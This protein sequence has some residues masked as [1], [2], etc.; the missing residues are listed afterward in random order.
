MIDIMIV[1]NKLNMYNDENEDDDGVRESYYYVMF[2]LVVGGW[3][4]CNGYV[5]KCVKNCFG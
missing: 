1:F 3:C 5:F 2:D 4:K